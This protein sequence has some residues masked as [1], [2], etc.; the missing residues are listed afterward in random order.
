MTV[1][2]TGFRPGSSA[3]TGAANPTL[4]ALLRLLM[5]TYP[6]G[7]ATIS[8]YTDASPAP[9]GNIRLSSQRAEAIA[10]W[11]IAHGVAAHRLQT[12]GFGDAD[13]VAPN[14]PGGQ[15]LNRRVVIVIDPMSLS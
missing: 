1:A 15:P 6:R 11:L 2:H 5:V 3:L 14:L 4:W 12:F 13:P 9:G 10:N 7:T 8:G